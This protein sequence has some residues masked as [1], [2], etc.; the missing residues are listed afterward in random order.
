MDRRIELLPDGK[1]VLAENGPMRMVI[2][3]F[4]HGSPHQDLAVAGAQFA[5]VCLEQVAK[6]RSCLMQRNSRALCRLEDKDSDLARTMIR[7]VLAFDEPDLTPMAAVAGTMADAVAD[8]LFQRG[9]TRVIVNNGGD[10]AIRLS[11]T[12]TVR[13]GIRTDINSPVVSHVMTLD[14]RQTSWGVNTSGVGGRSLTRGIASAVT[15]LSHT[16]ALADAAATA[17]AN[18]CFSKHEN[19][20]QVPARQV[21]P[22]TD[23]PDIPVTVRVGPL[24]SE[25]YCDALSTA[26][27][28][29]ER[30]VAQGVVEGAFI[31]AGGKEV[32]TRNF[33]DRVVDITHR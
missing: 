19:I 17:L 11:G 18:A 30:Y 7:S 23:I 15:V 10:I 8:W 14:A 20:L 3:A 32:W 22:G 1:G 31:A 26:L 33:V 5:F 13:V 9:M 28:N 16:S 4:S 21:D 27:D 29:A 24:P 12:E 2:Q 6:Y 25:T